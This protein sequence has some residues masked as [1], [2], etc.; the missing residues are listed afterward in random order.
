MFKK[1]FSKFQ[2]EK[3]NSII[4]CMLYFILMKTKKKKRAACNSLYTAAEKA[5]VA[6]ATHCLVS[7]SITL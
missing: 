2:F 7:L 6:R 3:I 4:L 1:L 5:Y